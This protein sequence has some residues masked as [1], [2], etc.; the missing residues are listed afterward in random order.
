MAVNYGKNYK[1]SLGEICRLHV[2]MCTDKSQRILTYTTPRDRVT[3]SISFLAS[4][5]VAHLLQGLSTATAISSQE[6]NASLAFMKVINRYVLYILYLFIGRFFLAYIAILGF[7]I[8]SLRISANIRLCYLQA[9]FQ[10]SISTLD[11]LPPGQ[12]TA[13]ITSTANTLQLGI[14]ERLSSLIQA[15]TVITVAFV[16]GCIFSWKL[17]LVTASGVVVIAWWYLFITP[18]VVQQYVKVQELE[19]EAAG[20]A[21]ES[22]SGIKMIAAYGAE[23]KFVERYNEL[24][25]RITLMSR[26]LSPVLAVQHAPAKLYSTPHTVSV[27][28]L[29][30]VLMSAM[31]ILSH[32]PAVSVPLTSACNAVNAAS[33]FFTVIDAPKPCTTGTKGENVFSDANVTLKNINFAYPLRHDVK[34]LND[35][36]L[37][38]PAGKTTAIVGPSGSGKSTV[39]ALLQRWYELGGTDPRAN[40]LRN[41]TIEIGNTKLSEIDLCWWRSQI[42]LVQQEPCL[43]N[44]TIYKNVEHGLVNTEWEYASEDLKRTMVERACKEAYADEFIQNLPLGYSTVVGPMGLHFSGGQRQRIA[45]ARA[46]VRQPKILLFDEATSALDV[47]SERIVQAALESAAQFRTTIVIAHRLSTIRDAHQIVV[48]AKGRVVQSGTHQSL[49]LEK[50]GTYEKLVMAQQIGDSCDGAFQGQYLSLKLNLLK[51]KDSCETMVESETT[52]VEENDDVAIPKTMSIFQSFKMLLTEQRENWLGYLMLTVAAMGAAGNSPLQAYLFGRIISSFSYPMDLVYSSIIFMCLML[53]AVAAGTGLSYSVIGFVSNIVSVRTVATYRKEYFRNIVTKRVSFFDQSAHTVGV[54]TTNLATDPVQLQQL[55]GANMAMVLI[56]VFGLIGCVVIAVLFHWK[57]G[58][59]VIASSLPIILAGGWYRVRYEIVFEA[60][61]NQVF[62]ESASFA[63]EAIG[64]MRTVTSLTLERTVCER[65]AKLLTEHIHTSWKAARLAC[66][67]FAASDSMVLLCMAFALWYGG[68]L[69]SRLEIPAFN[70]LVVYLAIIQG[71]LAAGQWLSFGPNIAQV[72]AAAQRIQTMRISDD[73]D[74]NVVSEKF[75][76]THRWSLPTTLIW[77]G[78]D[79]T[80]QN[81]WFTYPTRDTPVL[82]GLSIKIPHGCFAAIVGSSGSGKTTLISLLERFYEPTSGSIRYNN[83][84]I[85]SIPLK[86]LRNRMSLVTQESSLSLFRGTIRDN[87]LLGVVSEDDTTTEASLHQA[88]RAAGIHDF[89][90]SLPG[91]YDTDVGASGVSLSGGQKQRISIARALIRDP[92][93]LLLDEATSSLD[94]ESERDI[95]A[96]FEQ[97]GRGRTMIAVAHRLATVKGADIIFVMKNGRLAEK[98]DHQ[99]LLR[100]KGIYWQMSQCQE[101]GIP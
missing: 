35:L 75:Q 72:S 38:I 67:I 78:A 32:I 6:Q 74:E 94:S 37:T 95:Q 41:G 29:I 58:I 43:F 68:T 59:V 53:L 86:I 60:A 25:E 65:Y 97:S 12:T 39:I 70:F 19:R 33:I 81:V 27:T 98:G 77:Q 84:E 73:E 7:R 101:L 36:T 99:T 76:D 82:Q 61:S 20:A 5:C 42:G 63:T 46:I 71:S 64:A 89:I 92:A 24:V 55:L 49:L 69:L 93:V 4:I 34:V 51:E 54:L 96:V 57:Y 8:T 2:L 13:I 3:L 100:Q 21:A 15:T 52:A 14:S 62:A 87:V 80:F 44:D 23:D 66:L 26:A 10:Q 30:V 48:V 28:K 16:I 22:L 40:Y 91:G 45:I 18:C 79:I 50:G 88:C 11:A 83:E 90:I 85:T 9:L 31:T 56:S 1:G 47:T 17:M